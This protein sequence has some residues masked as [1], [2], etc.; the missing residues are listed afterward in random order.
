M[1]EAISPEVVMSELKSIKEELDFIKKH[2]VD[3]DSLLIGDEEAR[4]E[5]SLKEYREGKAVSLEEFEKG[6]QDA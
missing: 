1:P 6:K 3:V 2:M 4:L 5:E